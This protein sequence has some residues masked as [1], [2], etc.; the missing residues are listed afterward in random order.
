MKIGIVGP[1]DR[2]VA[3]EEHLRPHRAVEEVIISGSLKGIGNVDACLLFDESENQLDSLLKSIQSGFHSFLISKLPTDYKAIE[4]IY[5]AAEEANVLLQFSHWPTLAPASQWMTKKIAKPRF[6][7]IIREV[8]YT[9]FLETGAAIEDLWI[10]ELAFCLKWIDGAVHNLDLKTV[11]LQSDKIHALHLYVRFDSGATSNIY[12]N[13]SSQQNSHRRFASDKSFLLHCDVQSQ[14]V[15]LG[16]ES[17]GKHL[18]F[19]KQ[20]FDPT[21]AAEMA[22]TQFIKAIQLK[23]STLYNGYDLQKLATEIQ[24]VREKISRA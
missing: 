15:R 6:I 20:E 10:D 14:T 18:F 16:Q 8:N 4:K 11:K 12:I 5:H 19:D 9:E 2:A 23:K 22:A 21:K 7:Q 3:W 1:A 17:S 13:A 24:K